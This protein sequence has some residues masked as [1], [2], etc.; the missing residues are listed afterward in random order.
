LRP[1]P[2]GSRASAVN[3]ASRGLA[4][5]RDGSRIFVVQKVEQSEPNVI[6]VRTGALR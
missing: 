6:H 2:I 1:T 3:V 4:V 5:S